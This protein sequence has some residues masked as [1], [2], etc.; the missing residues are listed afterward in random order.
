MRRLTGVH[1]R[2]CRAP[3]DVARGQDAVVQVAAGEYA[4]MLGVPRPA[5]GALVGDGQRI[6]GGDD[7]AV[8]D[9]DAVFVLV[10]G[11]GSLVFV[12]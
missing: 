8:V 11:V 10:C 1:A 9:V 3:V 4:S 7:L 12:R 2:F 5:K 6:V